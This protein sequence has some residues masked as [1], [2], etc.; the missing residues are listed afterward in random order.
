MKKTMIW[1]CLIL[2]LVCGAALAEA[3][4]DEAAQEEA[5]G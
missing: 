1:L 3:Q 2:L 4:Q 5:Q